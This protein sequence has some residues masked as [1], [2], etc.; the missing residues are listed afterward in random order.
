MKNMPLM[1]HALILQQSNLNPTKNKIISTCF[2]L[3]PTHFQ[4][5]TQPFDQAG[6]HE[7]YPRGYSPDRTAKKRA[8]DQPHPCSLLFA[9]VIF[10][11]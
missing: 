11:G 4:V 3:S 10:L 6:Q 5:S 2:L 9:L 8:Y 1:S 7:S